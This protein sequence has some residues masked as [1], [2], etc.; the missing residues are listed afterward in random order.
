M[1]P[2][3]LSLI[4]LGALIEA[5]G[6]T[7]R[8]RPDGERHGPCPKCGGTDRFRVKR[9]DGRDWFACRQCHDKPGDAIDYLRWLHGLTYPEALARLGIA[10]N[11]TPPTTRPAR[12]AR[13]V[14]ALGKPIPDRLDDPPSA[15]WQTG[16]RAL[17]D[18]CAARLWSPA[19]ARALSYLR[20]KRLLTDATLTA[21]G[22]GY[23]D[24]DRWL[25]WGKLRVFAARGLTIPTD[26]G[27]D[28]WRVNIRRPVGAP[29]YQAVTGSRVQLFNGDA[30]A[31]R[32]VGAAVCA[33]EFD[34]MLAQQAVR[35]GAVAVTFGSE[36]KTPTWEARYLLRG[37]RVVIVYDADATGE[38][39][40]RR[41]REYAPWAEI[42][43]PTAH[44][45]TDMARA[46]ANVGDWLRVLFAPPLPADL[47]A[48]AAIP[49]EWARVG[50]WGAARDYTMT[51]SSDGRGIMTRTT[52]PAQAVTT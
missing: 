10:G 30:L 28:L 43:K 46:G 3:D 17:V 39:G 7:L 20:E 38:A 5:D 33:G 12:R 21:Y 15:D 47:E 4:D 26:Y 37:R 13:P 44:D 2:P 41:W 11:A 29:K 6:V 9:Y 16:A 40:A 27:G 22:I 52:T 14:D 31:S 51:F 32:L 34:A 1:A 36:T 42:V 23:N 45:L 8:G 19:G 49:D 25:T 48:V 24:A 35:V 18:D 50:A